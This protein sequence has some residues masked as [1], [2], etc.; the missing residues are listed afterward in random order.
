M[1]S[2]II[3]QLLNSVFIFH[4]VFSV[5]LNS[6]ADH[7]KREGN[8]LHFIL[9]QKRRAAL[10]LELHLLVRSL[11]NVVDYCRV[12][13]SEQIGET[14]LWQRNY[15]NGQSSGRQ[16]ARTDLFTIRHRPGSLGLP[17]CLVQQTQDCSSTRTRITSRVLKY[18]K[19]P[20]STTQIPV[21]NPKFSFIKLEATKLSHNIPKSSS[22]VNW[23]CTL[24]ISSIVVAS[25]NVSLH[26]KDDRCRP[27]KS[28]NNTDKPARWVKRKRTR[29][30]RMYQTVHAS[31]D[32]ARV[33]LCRSTHTTTPS[34]PLTCTHRTLRK[35]EAD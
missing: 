17:S 20:L 6:F 14:L 23:R 16:V 25:F 18:L 28:S 7:L 11:N 27:N 2:E 29:Y 24:L 10:H 3:A 31:L 12:F 26:C 34:S 15:S 32:A 9:L 33:A 22:R 1:K 35:K 19:T 4:L 8:V 13:K 21:S 30:H 5:L